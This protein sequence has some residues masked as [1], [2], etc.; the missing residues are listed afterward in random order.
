MN[1]FGTFGD[2]H[3]TI[4]YEHVESIEWKLSEVGAVELTINMASGRQHSLTVDEYESDEILTDF[5]WY[6]DEFLQRIWKY[7]AKARKK[8]AKKKSKILRRFV[9]EYGVE[10]GLR[11]F[12]EGEEPP[13]GDAAAK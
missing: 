6:R 2:D 12:Q 9:E 11:R 13:L 1:A 7:Q 10:E 5:T 3:I 4:S 8:E